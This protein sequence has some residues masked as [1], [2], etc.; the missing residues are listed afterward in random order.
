[1][2]R[3]SIL[4]QR[5][6]YIRALALVLIVCIL[7]ALVLMSD[8]AQAEPAPSP[9]SP[10]EDDWWLPEWVEPSDYSGVYGGY[11]G[12]DD[13]LDVEDVKI[14]WKEVNPEEGV[15][16]W[17]R[18]EE[19]LESGDPVWLRFF[20]S[21]VL[22]VP[23]WLKEKY[24][25]LRVHRYR[26]PDGGYDDIVGYNYGDSTTHSPGDFYEIWDPRFEAEY[27]KLLQ[28]FKQRFGSHPQIKF[29]Y[30]N[31]AWRWGEWT[32]KWVPEMV[33]QGTTP[34]EYIAWFKRSVDASIDAFD[35]QA[36]KLVYTGTGEEE[37]IEWTGDEASYNAWNDAIN[38]PDGGNVLSKYV[39]EQGLGVRDGWTEVFNFYASRPDWG[40]NLE[41][42]GDHRYS[43]IDEDHPLIATPD[44]FFGTENEDY[45]YLWNGDRL[46]NYYFNKMANLN[47]LRL[48]MNW[49]FW[50][51]YSVAPEIFEYTRKTMGKTVTDSPDAWVALRQYAV[52]PE[53]GGDGI[54]NIRNYERWVMQRDVEPNGRT[55]ATHRIDPPADSDGFPEI[56]GG[57][58]EALRTDHT[59]GSDY[60]YFD[61][62]DRFIKGGSNT[63]Q[64]KVTYL[65]NFEGDWWIEY[66]A[67]GGKKYK[68]TNPHTNANDKQW[69]TVTFEVPDAAFKN[70]QTD[71]MDF[72]IYNG[73]QDDIAVR[74]VRVIKLNQPNTSN[75][76]P[77][78]LPLVQKLTLVDAMSGQA[79][80]D[81]SMS[82]GEMTLDLNTLPADLSLQATID[83]QSTES[84][85]FAVDGQIAQTES[86]SP[87]CLKGDRATDST[88]ICNAVSWLTTPGTYELTV[89]PFAEDRG[90]GKQGHEQTIQVNVVQ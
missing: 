50:G 51:D 59:N 71:G 35:G 6:F 36:G 55:V 70:G 43:V 13:L 61:V 62:E 41:T 42:I 80:D 34:E 67:A 24:P 9:Q 84:I 57:S 81:Y 44:R 66:D 18:L 78:Y 49:V 3:T 74:F 37:W 60:M 76:S 45:Y 39:L 83:E 29:A 4:L 63:I 21:D 33:E 86:H 89:T 20:A 27:T 25:D 19:A 8:A 40:T 90:F 58:Y 15:Y 79:I 46:D 11:N 72:R 7:G 28:D 73:G 54:E 2:Q 47:M 82:D 69:K 48:R 5:S 31:T 14:V 52:M 87:Y 10:Q 64:I 1:M 26:W 75:P 32:V 22:H 23:G 16:D 38:T 85:E 65:D 30:M 17:W 12:P 88:R 53:M 56:N 68:A 77:V